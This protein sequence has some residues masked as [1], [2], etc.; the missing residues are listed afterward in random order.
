MEPLVAES[1]AGSEALT[2]AL[3]AF[4]R[5]Y[6]RQLGLLDRNLLGSRWTLAELRVLHEIN[7][8]P[9]STAR[10]IARELHLD[11]AYLS[12]IL[13]T[14]IR[15]RLVTRIPS[16]QDARQ[17]HLSLTNAGR[18]A[19][20]LAD[21]A[22]TDQIQNLIAHLGE[23]ARAQ[24]Q[25]A[26]QKV[27]RLLRLGPEASPAASIRSLRIGDIGWII[28]RQ[29]LLYAQEYG[30][31]ISYEAL[32]AEI[33]SAF[34]TKFDPRTDGAWIAEVEGEIV[35]SVFLVRKS[36]NV[37]Q[38]RLLYVEPHTR[39][40]GIGAR[41]V[42]E[43]V[44][45]ARERGYHELMLWTNDVLVAA[46]RIYQSAGFVLKSEER[47]HSFGHDLVGQIW[48]LSLET[49]GGRAAQSP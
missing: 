38:L 44:R 14:F 10:E 41:L 6:T 20:S 24:L 15:R 8:R 33:L 17:R 32:V 9:G 18:S 28:H 30:W 46:R 21:Q 11:E 1:R 48:S 47:H 3:R 36:K 37:G 39:G 40:Q 27:T 49:E 16:S 29:A 26:L 7:R 12:R 13:A 19:F 5:A 25:T 2:A 22:A 42:G 43:C 35:G 34:V 4:N 45:G 31:D 23:H